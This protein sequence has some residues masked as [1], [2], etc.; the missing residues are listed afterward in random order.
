M[1]TSE[2][3]QDASAFGNQ[4]SGRILLQ[5]IHASFV[6]A[7]ITCTRCSAALVAVEGLNQGQERRLTLT[8]TTKTG[9]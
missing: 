4:A 3:E 2:S 1:T 8:L 7:L 9:E 6:I 5:G